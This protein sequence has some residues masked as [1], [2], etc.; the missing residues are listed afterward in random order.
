MALYNTIHEW[1]D[2]TVGDELSIKGLLQ[3]YFDFTINAE[4]KYDC[5]ALLRS[6]VIYALLYGKEPNVGQD[7]VKSEY[8]YGALAND[9]WRVRAGYDLIKVEEG[10]TFRLHG[11]TLNSF[12]CPTDKL[13]SCENN[14][15]F[16]NYKVANSSKNAF[17]EK[18]KS[19]GETGKF[20][21]LCINEGGNLP[22]YY[23]VNYTIGNFMP[24]PS[25][26]NNG[27]G[28]RD[29]FP[30]A[31][32]DIY[33][34]CTG[35]SSSLYGRKTDYTWRTDADCKAW[36]NNYGQF[37]DKY[38][39]KDKWYAFVERNMLQDFLD[40]DGKPA[41]LYGA[42]HTG[43]LPVGKEECLRF[44]TNASI[45]ILARGARVAC[46]LVDSLNTAIAMQGGID[47]L[48]VFLTSKVKKT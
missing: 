48:A 4:R 32:C 19:D 2:G 45:R 24:V 28:H 18:L 26:F 7:N 34:K 15:D 35:A 5:D 36:L 16:N 47:K 42:Q 38:T 21:E 6:T 12:W 29:F 13:T 31:M 10:K 43:S 8:G 27:K 14:G 3:K 1:P 46:A 40:T 41:V 30:L 23:L 39:G 17:F 20:I 44:F 37:E 22:V 25:A 11:D 33:E 9:G